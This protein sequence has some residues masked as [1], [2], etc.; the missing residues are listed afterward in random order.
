MNRYEHELLGAIT[1]NVYFSLIHGGDNQ[2]LIENLIDEIDD[3]IYN[4][5]LTSSAD[6]LNSL[7]RLI[8][9]I[10]I[11]YE[12]INESLINEF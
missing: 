7:Y 11:G 1:Q 10:E 8:E 3:V 2:N 4:L 6:L 12:L 5:P 9:I